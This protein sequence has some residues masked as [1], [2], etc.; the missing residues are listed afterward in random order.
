MS[1]HHCRGKKTFCVHMQR[2]EGTDNTV[3]GASAALFPSS[4]HSLC[5]SQHDMPEAFASLSITC[6]R[7]HL[8]VYSIPYCFTL[9]DLYTTK[10]AVDPIQDLVA[11]LQERLA[12]AVPSLRYI[13]VSPAAL[14]DMEHCSAA[15]YDC[16]D[17]KYQASTY[18]WRVRIPECGEGAG[19]DLGAREV[20]RISWEE[21]VRVWRAVMDAPSRKDVAEVIRECP[22]DVL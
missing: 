2:R 6:L 14:P 21:G 20:E 11:T 5:I 4:L 13:A 10:N 9:P 1:D 7:L 19:N 17:N 8:A 3:A 22:G 16:H 18:W 15:P 12:R